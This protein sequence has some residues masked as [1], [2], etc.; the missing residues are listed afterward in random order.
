MTESGQC[1]LSSAPDTQSL[2]KQLSKASVHSTTTLAQQQC[3]N[4]YVTSTATVAVTTGMEISNECDNLVTGAS[5]LTTPTSMT[6][7]SYLVLSDLGQ[8]CT[9]TER[10]Y[11]AT[12]VSTITVTEGGNSELTSLTPATSISTPTTTISN[13]NVST[14]SLAAT[15]TETKTQE[16]FTQASNNSD[17]TNHR[18][19]SSSTC[20]QQSFIVSGQPTASSTTATIT[21]NQQCNETPLTINSVTIGDSIGPS[22]LPEL[23]LSPACSAASTFGITTTAP[24]ESKNGQRNF[25]RRYSSKSNILGISDSNT[26]TTRSRSCGNGESSTSTRFL[27]QIQLQLDRWSQQTLSNSKNIVTTTLSG[28]SVSDT[29]TSSTALL[30]ELFIVGN[31]T[32]SSNNVISTS[33]NT[34]QHLPLHS[35]PREQQSLHRVYTFPSDTLTITNTY[36]GFL[37]GSENLEIGAEFGA[38]FNVEFATEQSTKTSTTSSSVIPS[39]SSSGGSSGSK[40]DTA[41]TKTTFFVI[42]TT[43]PTGKMTTATSVNNASTVKTTISTQQPLSSMKCT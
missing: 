3:S 19:A 28:S 38:D 34:R 9:Y 4:E 33:T 11:T 35:V 20:T 41:T 16:I 43:T 13:I 7:N 6:S 32:L 5:K 29:L 27:K 18:P 42:I 40:I 31:K 21:A 25:N 2:A 1:V 8:K 39:V 30:Q 24:T 37:S 36:L 17:D 22:S 23:S 10:Q 15:V 26:V 14:C 12:I